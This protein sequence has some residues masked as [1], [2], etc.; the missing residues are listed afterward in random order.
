VKKLTLAILVFW[1]V[2]A[3]L[4]GSCAR[5]PSAEG[6]ALSKRFLAV[7]PDSL[8]LA[9][10]QEIKGLLETFWQ[11]VEQGDV[12]PEDARE[13]TQKLRGYIEGGRIPGQELLH[14]MALVGYYSYRKDPRYN[15]PDGVVDHP[16]LNP[17]AALVRFSPDS[18]GGSWQLYWL[19]PK[20]KPDST[21]T[22]SSGG[23]PDSS[24]TPR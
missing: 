16:T 21:K 23:R 18:T 10:R 3:V 5:S 6:R 8:D 1:A 17:N 22:P 19:N 7:L 2:S 11:R 14:F 13:V 15:L 4:S 20:L 9:H 24:R 12:L